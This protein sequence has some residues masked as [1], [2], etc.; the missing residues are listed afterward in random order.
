MTFEEFKKMTYHTFKSIRI[1]G[2]KTVIDKSQLMTKG[3]FD[4]NKADPV[5]KQVY[6]QE[7]YA[8][9]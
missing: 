1:P 2:S 6:E 4:Q 7:K 3:R 9:R 8:N 5:L